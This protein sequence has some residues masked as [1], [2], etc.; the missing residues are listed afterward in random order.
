MSSVQLEMKDLDGKIYA[1]KVKYDADMKN[2][3]SLIDQCRYKDQAIYEIRAALTLFCQQFAFGNEIPAACSDLLNCRDEQLP[4][5]YS[6]QGNYQGSGNT[7]KENSFLSSHVA[8]PEQY[9]KEQ[10]ES[11]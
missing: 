4:Y 2:I 8:T 5:N 11:I 7:I 9:S 10:E 3:H 6:F 1:N